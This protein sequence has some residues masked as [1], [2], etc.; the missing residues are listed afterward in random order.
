[1]PARS[2]TPDRAHNAAARLM[3]KARNGNS[4][5][6]AAPPTGTAACR[7]PKASPMRRVGPNARALLLVRATVGAAAANP[8]SSSPTTV[9]VREPTAAPIPA[10]TRLA[11]VSA[12]PMIATRRSVA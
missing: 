7:I 6:A 3:R 10:S 12:R 5:P 4:R 8:A 1:M 9:P 11:E 2:R